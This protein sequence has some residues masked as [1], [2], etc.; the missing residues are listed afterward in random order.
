VHA[1]LTKFYAHAAGDYIA[2]VNSLLT[3]QTCGC[4]NPIVVAGCP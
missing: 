2:Q 1:L 3:T 4:T